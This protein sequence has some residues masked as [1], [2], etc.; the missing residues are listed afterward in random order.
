MQTQFIILMGVSGSG[1]TTIGR[2]LASRLGWNFYDADDFHPAENIA[3]MTDGIPLTDSD[4]IPWLTTLH[5]LI[6]KSLSEKTPGV[7]GCSALKE[8]YLKI[9]LKG[10]SQI[11]LVY[12]KGDPSLLQSRMKNRSDHYMKPAL[13]QSQFEIL[14]EP[15]Y[16]LV[17]DISQSI[18]E[19]L[20]RI[21]FNIP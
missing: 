3:K 4:R 5:N 12:L 20:D 19:I 2:L 15:A 18:E 1:K 13:L 11:Q 6:T 17:V 8:S 9:L 14:E 16:A 21:L 10:T 7:L